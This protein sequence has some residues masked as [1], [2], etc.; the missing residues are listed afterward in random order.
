VYQANIE[1]HREVHRH[2]GVGAL[3]I[4]DG[5]LDLGQGI[6]SLPK[7][8]TLVPAASAASI[9]AKVTRDR[10]MVE[11]NKVWPGFGFDLHMGYGVPAHQDALA[12]LGPCPIHR[13]SYAPIAALL[14]KDDEPREAWLLL[15]DD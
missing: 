1:A 8:D 12:K 4:A 10:E 6:V 3:H 14:P 9:I 11:L 5:N 2:F 7:A 15:D 13:K